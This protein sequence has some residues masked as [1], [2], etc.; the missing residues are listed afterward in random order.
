[1]ARRRFGF[2]LALAILSGAV[3]AQPAP[4]Y[5]DSTTP[6]TL[7]TRLAFAIREGIRRSAGFRLVDRDAEAGIAVRLVTVSPLMGSPVQLT[8]YSVVWTSK[9]LDEPQL[10]IYLSQQVGVCG[11][12]TLSECAEGIIAKT[13]EHFHTMS[14]AFK[15]A[16]EKRRK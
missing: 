16:L 3:L 4:V 6:D 2:L 8:S 10:P 12:D 11:T 5:V 9:R 13:D 1:M 15:D 14:A 7:G